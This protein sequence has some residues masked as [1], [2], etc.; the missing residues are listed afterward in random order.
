MSYK[1]FVF[2]GP[3][4][5]G[6]T[7]AV[8][9]KKIRLIKSGFN[10]HIIRLPSP[11][12]ILY[13]VIRSILKDK[14]YIDKIF[15]SEDLKREVFYYMTKYGYDLDEF[16]TKKES[17]L[18]TLMMINMKD[19]INDEALSK[20]GDGSI[21]LLDRSFISTIVYGI[22]NGN[23][24]F[25]K[26]KSSNGKIDLNYNWIEIDKVY[27]FNIGLDL[28]LKH[29]SRRQKLEDCEENDKTDSV[30]ETHNLYNI[31]INKISDQSKVM[32]VCDDLL[33]EGNEVTLYKLI[34]EKIHSDIIE[35][36]KETDE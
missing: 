11:E 22:K 21:I 2:E 12:G 17:L 28:L 15:D 20:F 18:Q 16:K 5:S 13:S 1:L 26:Y 6:K 10:T 7:H 19:V 34:Y 27:Y 33:Y 3:D 36:C 31:I 4:G 14:K 24:M 30:L 32:R 29:A 25:M 23:P 9:E 35:I 8:E